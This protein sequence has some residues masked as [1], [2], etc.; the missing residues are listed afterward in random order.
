ML[1]S[2]PLYAASSKYKNRTSLVLEMEREGD[3]VIKNGLGL[4]L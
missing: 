4:I 2:I 1:A 3:S